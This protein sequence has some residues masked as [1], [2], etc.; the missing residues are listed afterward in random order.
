MWEGSDPGVLRAAMS[1]GSSVVLQHRSVKN[2]LYSCPPRHIA[3]YVY[4]KKKRKKESTY[5]LVLYADM[6]N[7]HV[8]VTAYECAMDARNT[9]TRTQ[10]AIKTRASML[11]V[12]LLLWGFKF[13]HATDDTEIPFLTVTKVAVKTDARSYT[14]AHKRQRCLWWSILS[15]VALRGASTWKPP[16]CL[17]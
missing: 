11:N 9:H 1:R 17:K 2:S 5:L 8:C 3:T 13:F 7:I 16:S 10:Y 15:V 4:L 6:K 12:I 14:C